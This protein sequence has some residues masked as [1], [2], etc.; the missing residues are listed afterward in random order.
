MPAPALIFFD[1][2]GVLVEI[3]IFSRLAALL[4]P[5]WDKD[6]LRRRWLESEAVAAYELGRIGREEFA[7]RFLAEW[8]LALTPAAFLAEFRDWARCYFPGARELVTSLRRQ[9]RVACLSNCNE[10][11]WEKF[12][13]FAGL[14]DFTLSSHLIG[15]M[16]PDPQ[17]FR[18]ASELAGLCPQEILFLD[19]T[20]VNVDTAR[21][22][23]WQAHQVA[24][25]GEVRQV[26][27]GYGFLV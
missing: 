9:V 21:Q 6:S 13:G 2:G 27:S 8:Q 19:D 17:A 18:H 15:C 5:G 10:L 14:F 7:A 11:H 4:P 20:P 22:L 26:L 16:K 24:G 3:A 25:L 1:L 12:E 23:G